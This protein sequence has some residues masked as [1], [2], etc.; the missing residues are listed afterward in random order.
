MQLHPEKSVQK[1]DYDQLLQTFKV[2]LF[3]L[4]R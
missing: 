2:R 1:I 4:L 3:P